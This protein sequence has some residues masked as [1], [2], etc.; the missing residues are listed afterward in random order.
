[1]RSPCQQ[2]L[3]PRPVRKKL[4]R[5][6]REIRG[7]MALRADLRRG[8]PLDDLTRYEKSVYSQNGEDG[9]LRAIFAR[10]GPGTRYFVEFGVEDGT[11]CNTRY[12]AERQG[13]TGL[14]MD[15]GHTDPRR[16]LHREMITVENVVAL[17][18][19]YGVP[20]EFD[21]LS[22][23]IDG[24]DYWVWRAIATVWRPR[25]VVIEYNASEGPDVSTSIVYDPA[26]RW[27]ETNY[28]GA[29][30]RALATLGA[31]HGYTLV[32]CDSRGVNALFV[33]DEFVRDNFVRHSVA[34]LYRPPRFRADGGHPPDPSRRMPPV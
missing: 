3:G 26:F 6:L 13:W 19:K 15:G 8:G 29:S 34:E 27:S 32:A 28:M 22:I 9:I 7:T 17:F 18:R 24:N 2:S 1:V 16:N 30:L 23:D 5:F 21:L 33:A 25:V 20:A 12:L 11:Q 10:I 31:S 14:L 4:K